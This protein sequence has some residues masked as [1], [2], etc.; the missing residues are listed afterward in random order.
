MPIDF[1]EANKTYGKPKNMTDEECS[2]L[3]VLERFEYG[4]KVIYSVWQPSKED[5]DAFNSGRPLILRMMIPVMVP[6]A[7]YTN[8]E[9]IKP[10]V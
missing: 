7:M 2:S 3:R 9:N 8:D 5:I 10:N 6:I 1:D 4:R